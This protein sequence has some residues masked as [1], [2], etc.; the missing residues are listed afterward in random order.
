MPPLGLHQVDDLKTTGTRLLTGGS[1]LSA[2]SQAQEEAV[3]FYTIE[4]ES[5]NS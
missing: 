1:A 3:A 5:D 4:R 2:E